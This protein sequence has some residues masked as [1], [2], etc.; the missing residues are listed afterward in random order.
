MG[1]RVGTALR[2]GTILLVDPFADERDMYAESLRFAGFDVC[3]CATPSAAV[4]RAQTSAVQAVI[5]RIRQDGDVNGIALTRVLKGDARTHSVRVLVITTDMEAQIR[6]GA[7]DAGC[8]AFL[9][10]PCLPD[11]LVFELRRLL[12]ASTHAE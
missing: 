9:L 3:V 6:A 4:A 5:T 1:G 12:Q 10:L 2:L 7:Y 11:E 8:D